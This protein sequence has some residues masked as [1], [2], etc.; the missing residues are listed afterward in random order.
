MPIAISRM[1]SDSA[2]IYGAFGSNFKACLQR[3]FASERR[4]KMNNFNPQAHFNTN[5]TR[6]F[7]IILVKIDMFLCAMKE[8]PINIACV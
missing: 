5:E 6:S 1:S 8:L 3:R 7:Q 2:A 4:S